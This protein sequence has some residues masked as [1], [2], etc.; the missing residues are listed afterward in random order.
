MQYM[1]FFL[2]YK[3]H[4]VQFS[5]LLTYNYMLCLFRAV[6]NILYIMLETIRTDFEDKSEEEKNICEEL[7]D[8]VC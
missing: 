4:I 3:H 2:L 6:L 7:K 5:L 8:Y 1:N